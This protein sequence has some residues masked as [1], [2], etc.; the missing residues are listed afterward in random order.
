LLQHPHQALAP[1]LEL[2]EDPL[3]HDPA[4]MPLFG[5]LV[6]REPALMLAQVARDRGE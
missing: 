2:I 4:R 5:D 1:E 6:M 3:Q